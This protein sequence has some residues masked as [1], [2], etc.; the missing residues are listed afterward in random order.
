MLGAEDVLTQES[1]FF[2]EFGSET[3]SRRKQ[4]KEFL[5]SFV[6]EQDAAFENME[7]PAGSKLF[8]SKLI[9]ED[10]LYLPRRQGRTH[11]IDT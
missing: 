8:A 7:R 4:Y 2:A 5:Q 3:V 9:K 10:G 1:P 6:P 11:N